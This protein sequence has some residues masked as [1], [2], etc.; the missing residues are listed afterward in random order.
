MKNLSFIKYHFKKIKQPSIKEIKSYKVSFYDEICE[1]YSKIKEI[2]PIS[3]SFIKIFFFQ[4]L[5]ICTLFIINFLTIWF[6]ILKLIFIYK[7]T[8]LKNASF[9]CVIGV[10][11][12]IY[13]I[14]LKKIIVTK[15]LNE[16]HFLEDNLI[17]IFHLM[18][19][20]YIYLNS[21]Y[22]NTF[23]FQIKELLKVLI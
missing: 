3:Y 18:K 2:I 10:D 23:I 1:D 16:S 9:V 4:F 22:L 7:K 6:P 15:K 19:M 14:D 11:S 8:S 13:I 17:Q 5:S 21:N 12:K 20:N